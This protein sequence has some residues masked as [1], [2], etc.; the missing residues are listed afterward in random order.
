MSF[1]L[2]QSEF[3]STCLILTRNKCLTKISI[4]EVQCWVNSLKP[5]SIILCLSQ[6]ISTSFLFPAILSLKTYCP[7]SVTVTN[8]T[9]KLPLNGFISQ[10]ARCFSLAKLALRC[11]NFS[12][13]FDTWLSYLTVCKLRQ[14]NF[15]NNSQ[16]DKLVPFRRPYFL[17]LPVR[18][19]SYRTVWSP[20]WKKHASACRKI[21]ISKNVVH[22]VIFWSITLK[23]VITK[24]HTWN[25]NH[26]GT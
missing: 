7:T 4:F 16:F 14:W 8:S 17:E 12:Y 25:W 2:F 19:V 10:S 18:T 11:F 1:S 15:D 20:N 3:D 6:R 22:N 26:L 9:T 5:F 23:R 24:S 21:T 13:E